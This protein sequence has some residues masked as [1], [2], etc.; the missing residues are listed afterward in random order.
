ML[1]NKLKLQKAAIAA[2]PKVRMI[3][4]L[5]LDSLFSDTVC[6]GVIQFVHDTN[7]DI[8]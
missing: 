2:L 6:A 4:S 7:H 8:A 1:S 5:H 3:M